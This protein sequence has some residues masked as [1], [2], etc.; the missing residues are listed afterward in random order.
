MNFIQYFDV[1]N[2]IYLKAFKISFQW[3]IIEFI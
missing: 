3:D 1:R 2:M